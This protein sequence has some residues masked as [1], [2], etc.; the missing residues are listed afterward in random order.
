MFAEAV[1]AI[2]NGD[3]GG[4]RALLAAHPEGLSARLENG[5]EDDFARPYLLWFVAEAPIR[6]GALP[7]N[8]V[9]ITR[10]PLNA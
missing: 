6:H 7:A 5:R 10:A 9:E 1:A 4:L 8:I 3:L 2:D